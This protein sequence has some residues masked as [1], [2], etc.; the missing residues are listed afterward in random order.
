M[1]HIFLLDFENEKK[2]LRNDISYLIFLGLIIVTWPIPYLYTGKC[3]RAL[4]LFLF[5]LLVYCFSY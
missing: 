2:P 4:F 3:I 1:I 5:L